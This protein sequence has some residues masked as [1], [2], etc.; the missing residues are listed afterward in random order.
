MMSVLAIIPALRVQNNPPEEHRIG[1][2]GCLTLLALST[3]SPFNGSGTGNR[4]LYLH[5]QP[6]SC[7]GDAHGMALGAENADMSLHGCTVVGLG[8]ILKNRLFG[9]PRVDQRRYTN[10]LG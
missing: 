5:R 8:R 10:G 4:R 7:G 3:I 6:H 2:R 1:F 9:F